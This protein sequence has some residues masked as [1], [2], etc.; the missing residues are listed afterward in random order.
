[1]VQWC[2]NRTLI[3]QVLVESLSGGQGSSPDG[4]GLAG[5]RDGRKIQCIG[6]RYT[7]PNKYMFTARVCRMLHHKEEE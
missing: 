5:W 1:V 3:V 6:I 7:V 4:R 2:I